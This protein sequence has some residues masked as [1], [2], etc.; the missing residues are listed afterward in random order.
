MARTG[1]QSCLQHRVL[2]LEGV[3]DAVNR[4]RLAL[5]ASAPEGA[6]EVAGYRPADDAAFLARHPLV[7]RAK[8]ETVAVHLVLPLAQGHDATVRVDAPL[9][10]LSDAL[11]YL[12]TG[13]AEARSAVGSGSVPWRTR[14]KSSASTPT[15]LSTHSFAAL[16]ATAGKHVVVRLTHAQHLLPLATALALLHVETRGFAPELHVLVTADEADVAAARKQ[17]DAL[18]AS[19]EQALERGCR[20]VSLAEWTV[21][22]VELD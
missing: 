17:L 4:V 13:D 10:T 18:R 1:I 22:S 12:E 5:N 2:W 8:N 15:G 11:A 21:A 19:A 7:L 20:L 16:E 3:A 14:R 9:D 6:L